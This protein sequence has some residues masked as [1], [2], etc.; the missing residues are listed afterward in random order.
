MLQH[1]PGAYMLLGQ[2]P[3]PNL[4]NPRFDFNDEVA[5]IGASLLA[6]IAEIRTA[7]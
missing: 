7:A 4:H 1:V 3:G 5:P 6:R 2:G